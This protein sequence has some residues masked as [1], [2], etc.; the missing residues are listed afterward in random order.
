MNNRY[1][2]ERIVNGTTELGADEYVYEWVKKNLMD[3]AS[4]VKVS[5]TKDKCGEFQDEKPPYYC[6]QITV[7]NL[8]DEFYGTCYYPIHKKHNRRYLAVEY[9][10]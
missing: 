3:D 7:G 5:L 10:C 1:I 9:Y 8:A 6:D 2:P 4:I